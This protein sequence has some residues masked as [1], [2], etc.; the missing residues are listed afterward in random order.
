MVSTF[1]LPFPIG[2]SVNNMYKIGNNNF[3]V[4]KE[5]KDYKH[6]VYLML[7]KE[8][9]YKDQPLSFSMEVYPPDN[10]IRDLDNLLK[11]VLDSL[12]YAH[13]IDNDCN[14]HDLYVTKKNTVKDGLLKISL[15]IKD[16]NE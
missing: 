8:F 9:R 14:I 4:K 12:Q 15:K 1:E 7:L 11:L 13:V 2:L 6:M 5:A 3:Y 10:R 16:N